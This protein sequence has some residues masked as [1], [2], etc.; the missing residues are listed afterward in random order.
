MIENSEPAPVTDSDTTQSRGDL[1]QTLTDAGLDSSEID[2]VLRDIKVVPIPAEIDESLRPAF[3]ANVA[4]VRRELATGKD[5]ETAVKTINVANPQLG[6][7]VG[8]YVIACLE[9]T[10]RM[11]WPGPVVDDSM[12]KRRWYIGPDQG[13]EEWNKYKSRLEEADNVTAQAVADLDMS[14]TSTLGLMPAPLRPNFAGR[15]LVM[16]Y[17]QSGKT[18]NFMG[19]IAKAVDEGYK[20]V[21]VLSG[22]T[23]NLRDQT[24]TRFERDLALAD[25]IKWHWLTSVG[26]DFAADANAVNL[27]GGQSINVA[28]VKK[29]A[30]RLKKL[31]LWLESAGPKIRGGA[32][33]LVIDDE[34]DQASVNTGTARQSAVHRELMA[35][36]H[37]GFMP[38]TAYVGYSATPFANML[39]DTEVM[40]IYPRDFIAS[41][42]RNEG[43][44]GPAEMFGR[45]GQLDGEVALDGANIIR[46]ISN[47][48]VLAVRPPKTGVES[49]TPEV[50]GALLQSFLWFGIAHSLRVL[51]SG[52][53]NFFSTMMVHTSQN[54][55]PHFR[56]KLALEAFLAKNNIEKF[57]ALEAVAKSLYEREIGQAAN[58]EPDRP[59]FDWATIWAVCLETFAEVKIVVDNS[60]SMDRL[61]YNV[62]QIRDSDLNIVNRGPVI[63]VGGNTLS[64]GLTLE[65]LVSS[66]FL[67]TSN[68]YDSLLQMGRWFGYRPGY[69]D[70]QRIWMA[71]ESPYKLSYW[72]RQLAF[73]EEEIREQIESFAL[74]GKSPSQ[75]AVR[76]REL[77]GMAITAAAKMRS[78][79][80][81]QIS[82]SGTRI[83]TILFDESP[84]TQEANLT[85][86][87][88]FA[89]DLLAGGHSL[90]LKEQ[91]PVFEAVN[92]SEILRYLE[93]FQFHP[94]SRQVS[95]KPLRDYIL[96]RNAESEL[97]S[98]NIAFYSNRRPSARTVELASGLKVNVANRARMKPAAG[99]T[100]I[101][102]KTLMSIGDTVADAPEL[103]KLA[104]EKDGT[105]KFSRLKTLR[106]QNH[107]T[108]GTPLLGVYLIDKDSKPDTEESAKVRQNLEAEHDIV[109]LYFVFPESKSSTAIS[110][111]AAN[112]DKLEDFEE[113]DTE[114][115][116]FDNEDED[117]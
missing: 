66:Y 15:G 79:V 21:V 1:E 53:K 87:K 5:V 27:L 73:V 36:I 90:K 9:V 93:A 10:G 78:A 19:L 100:R 34:C 84:L 101:D 91:Q 61:N 8:Q 109:G 41:L 96:G 25:S 46:D 92:V 72:F 107:V 44:F 48:E 7:F 97:V 16:G 23:N 55:G 31:R 94:D 75:V 6:P 80:S 82:Y 14:T 47:E 56:T 83:Q 63:V 20:L 18:M 95:F 33:L 40:G 112:L 50:T 64:R 49:W 59:E 24:Q 104:L 42:P 102:I 62:G 65:G 111:K 45:D 98:W 68:A 32:P 99:E 110:Y 12:Y 116:P 81:A 74:E 57:H 115:N 76:I 37:E 117:D 2:N 103:K 89:R 105:L 4:Y 69:A 71:N 38:R 35:L 113:I 3:L 54:I 106:N 51:R 60:K 86:T 39:T 29:N 67:R 70:L 58:L 13:S 11:P 85:V 17:V 114:S 30:S 108:T 28:V 77:P 26:K 52:G 43:Y 22:V 88:T